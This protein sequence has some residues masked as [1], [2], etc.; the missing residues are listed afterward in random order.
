MKKFYLLMMFAL[1]GMV[2]NAAEVTINFADIY[3]TSTIS[4][5]SNESKTKDG[6]TFT[7]AKGNAQNPPAYNKVEEIR[8]YGGKSNTVIDGNIMTVSTDAG[9]VITKIVLTAGSSATWGELTSNIGSVTED[10]RNAIWTGEG[11]SVTFT[12]NRNSSNLSSSTQN[13]YASITITYE[14]VVITQVAT[15]TF[16]VESGEIYPDTEIAINC[17]TE[18]AAI[19]YRLNEDPTVLDY[20]APLVFTEIGKTVTVTAWAEAEGLEAS[21][22]AVATYNVVEKPATIEFTKVEDLSLLSTNDRVIIVCEDYNNAMSTTV[23]SNKIEPAEVSIDNGVINLPVNSTAAIF[24]VTSL[25][26]NTFTFSNGSNYLY[27]AGSKSTNLNYSAETDRIGFTASNS[28]NGILLTIGTDTRSVLFN[29]SVFGYYAT[30]NIGSGYYVVSLYKEVVDENQVATPIFS[31]TSGTYEGTQSLTLDCETEGAT[32]YYTMNGGEPQTYADAIELAEGEY[33]FVAWAEKDGMTKS[34]EVTANYTI[35]APLVA[36]SIAEFLALGAENTDREITLSCDLTVTYQGS[37]KEGNTTRDL[38]VQDKDGKG[39]LIFNFDNP[40]LKKG[41]VISGV[42]GKYDL[43]NGVPELIEPVLGEVKETVEVAPVSVD[44]SQLTVDNVNDY[45]VINNVELSEINGANATL[46]DETA[47]LALYNKYNACTYPEELNKK[48]FVTGIVSVY[49]NAVQIYPLEITVDTE[50]SVNDAVAN[51]FK[52]VAVANGIEVNVAEAGLV[53]VYNAAGQLVAN[54]NVAEG[55]TTINVAGG[56][57]IVKA[58]N[59]V[60]KVL[61]K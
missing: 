42:K 56:F 34:L 58:G 44:A 43:Y 6:F 1:L 36:N 7:F 26:E 24:S 51:E 28:G 32:I 37:T 22:Q 33:A 11:S 17:A 49:N 53:S 25:G 12:A 14:E 29:G 4:D 61:V 50:S 20:S 38:Y 15:P 19:K 8:L 13:R 23:S 57:Y 52:A 27:A 18:G 39:L 54:V 5:I 21:E 47:T 9:R 41:D 48:Y 46:N 2:A 45:V 35:V 60:A 55:A 30:S 10:S 59:N 31:L 16:S 3:G 40:Q